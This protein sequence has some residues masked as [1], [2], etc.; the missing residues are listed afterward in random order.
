VTTDVRMSRAAGTGVRCAF[1]PG[2]L[3]F[4]ATVI[5]P[6]TDNI[7]VISNAP[8]SCF[9][10]RSR[11]TPSS[12]LFQFG[13]RDYAWPDGDVILDDLWMHVKTIVSME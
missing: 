11:E 7:G 5:C 2:M 3:C 10:V 9:A 1:Y 13:H 8:L 12:S 6:S 4:D